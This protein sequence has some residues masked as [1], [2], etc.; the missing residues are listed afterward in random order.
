MDDKTLVFVEVKT[1][2]SKEFGPP[3]KAITPWKIRR[4]TKT[5]QY[6][7]TLHPEIRSPIRLDA[8]AIK[9]LSD[10]EHKIK[11]IKNITL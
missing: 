4:M 7:L 8:V 6:F 3:E 11:L 5:A 9:M 1:R 2:V 10:G